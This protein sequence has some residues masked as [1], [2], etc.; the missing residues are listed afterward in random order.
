MSEHLCIPVGKV[1][2]FPALQRSEII[3]GK[4]LCRSRLFRIGRIQQRLLKDRRLRKSPKYLFVLYYH[5]I[6]GVT[7][8]A[9]DL[10]EGIM[11]IGLYLRPAL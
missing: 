1:E 2:S 5:C 6:K 4:L 3:K 10:H 7:D 9:D 8:A 11:R